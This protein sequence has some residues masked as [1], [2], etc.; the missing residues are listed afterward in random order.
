MYLYKYPCNCQFLELFYKRLANKPT[1]SI[2]RTVWKIFYTSLLVAGC[3]LIVVNYS[4]DVTYIYTST[5]VTF[6]I[7]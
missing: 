2:K 3:R 1:R 6:A 5:D 4:T 7:L